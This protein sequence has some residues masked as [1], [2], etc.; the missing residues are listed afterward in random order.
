MLPDGMLEMIEGQYVLCGL[1]DVS[2]LLQYIDFVKEDGIQ[3][4][5]VDPH[6]EEWI[7]YLPEELLVENPTPQQLKRII[8]ALETTRNWLWEQIRINVE[9]DLYC[10]DKWDGANESMAG[11]P[12]ELF[13][14]ELSHSAEN[15]P[16]EEIVLLW[17]RAEKGITD[18]LKRVPAEIRMNS[19]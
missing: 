14:M 17:F 18:L 15:L 8:K 10:I 3:Y 6:Y 5:I 2:H 16:K 12:N 11:K 4:A 7:R 19:Y 9:S 13:G 1:L